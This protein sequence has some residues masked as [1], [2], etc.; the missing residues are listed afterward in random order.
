MKYLLVIVIA[1]AILWL[2]RKSRR[3]G[4]QASHQTPPAKPA[5][6]PGVITEIVACGICQVH[7]PRA[8]AL[9]GPGGLYCCVAHRQQAGG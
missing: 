1:L 9:A 6:P 3:S 4:T 5:Q 2:W 7:L 8:E